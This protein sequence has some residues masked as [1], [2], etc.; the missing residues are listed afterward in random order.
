MNSEACDL[1]ISEEDLKKHEEFIRSLSDYEIK[2][3]LA[4]YRRVYYPVK[5]VDN[6]CRDGFCGSC[7]RASA[8]FYNQKGAC[9]WCGRHKMD[10]EICLT[11]DHWTKVVEHKVFRPI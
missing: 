1:K 11:C 10:K 5:P 3:L 9:V 2:E 4:L 7:G 6:N 8:I